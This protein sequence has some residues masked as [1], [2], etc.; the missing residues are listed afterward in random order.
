M[1]DEQML[2]TD[3]GQQAI[4]LLCKAFLRPG[5]AVALENPAYPGAIAIFAGA[6]IRALPV[7][8]KADRKA[9]AQ[10]HVGLDIEA[11]RSGADA[12]PREIYLA[13]ARF[14]QS[15][16]HRAAGAAA[17]A[18]CWRSPRTIRCR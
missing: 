17:P 11:L 5:D 16:R 4:D 15:Y 12:E 9:P 7:P 18:T 3:G 8:V 13:H 14:S 2:I 1:R 6:R 10:A